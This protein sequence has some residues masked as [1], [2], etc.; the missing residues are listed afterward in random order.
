M[1]DTPS[2]L[3]PTACLVLDT[4]DVTHRP[5][6]GCCGHVLGGHRGRGRVGSSRSSKSS[7]SE[8]DEDDDRLLGTKR[9][10]AAADDLSVSDCVRNIVSWVNAV[11]DRVL[12]ALPTRDYHVVM[13]G[14]DSAGKT[15]V[16]YRL[17]FDQYVNTVPTIGF[18]CEK[19]KRSLSTYLNI[20][21]T[22]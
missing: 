8:L 19:V 16:L 7:Y 20:L 22:M 9:T 21:S 1:Y 3:A 14:L 11:G 18:N 2:E 10:N 6:A 4:P 13:I 15:T 12:D 17:K 5:L